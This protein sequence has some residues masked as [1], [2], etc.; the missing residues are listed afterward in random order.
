MRQLGFAPSDVRLSGRLASHPSWRQLMAD[1][2]GQPVQSA[3]SHSSPALG[4]ALQAAVT[5]FQ[6]S[7]ENLSFAEMTSY[8][9]LPEQQT[10]CSPH[11]Q[12]HEFYRELMDRQHRLAESL[13]EE[14]F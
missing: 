4:A 12:R 7:G 1:V 14:P 9:V 2:L 11:P 8:A 13:R 6:Q 10:L 3:K 5:F